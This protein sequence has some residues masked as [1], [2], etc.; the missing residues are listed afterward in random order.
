MDSSEKL[1]DLSKLITHEIRRGHLREAIN[2]LLDV[3]GSLREVLGEKALE[4]A[5]AAMLSLGVFAS[6]PATFDEGALRA[7]GMVD[8]ETGVRLPDEEARILIDLLLQTGLI[9]R[10]EKNRLTVNTGTRDNCLRLLNE[11]VS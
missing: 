10:T 2:Q 4:K 1:P 6:E 11:E 8:E 5:E 7:T 3:R 9:R